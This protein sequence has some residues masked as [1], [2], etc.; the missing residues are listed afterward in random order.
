[1][2]KAARNRNAGV[3]GCTIDGIQAG[4]FKSFTPPTKSREVAKVPR[5]AEL[6]NLFTLGN[7]AV[8]EAKMKVG[9]MEMGPALIAK[10]NAL[11]DRK[12][13]NGANMRMNG[14]FD[15]TG[16]D[17]STEESY[18]FVDAVFKS[19]KL[20]D[21]DTASKEPAEVDLAILPETY[22]HTIGGG[23]KVTLPVNTRQKLAFASNFRLEIEGLEC[24]DCTKI[25]GM[26]VKVNTTT[27]LTGETI[28]P[29]LIVTSIDFP[30]KV[31]ITLLARSMKTWADWKKAC[32]LGDFTEKSGAIHLLTPNLKETLA[33]IEVQ[34]IG[35]RNL[36]TE[37]VE[38]NKAGS[39]TFTAEV[40]FEAMKFIMT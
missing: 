7:L 36:T 30:E 17:G 4:T 22:T 26:E 3:G 14:S 21:C 1:M 9:L 10:L 34:G 16:L 24:Q 23:G 37:G 11:L 28:E 29:E 19:V 2:A 38:N 33:T 18:S 35:L 40:Y 25:A 6:S 31:S 39:A 32:D 13:D 5:S 20:F 12:S 8:G 15:L 27:Q